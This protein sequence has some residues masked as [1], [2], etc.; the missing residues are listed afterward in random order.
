MACVSHLV[1][2]CDTLWELESSHA[3]KTINN[4]NRYIPN[5][6]FTISL[7]V[8]AHAKFARVPHLVA[9]DFESEFRVCLLVVEGDPTEIH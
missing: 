4:F 8:K 1:L 9:S 5:H 3:F 2:E 6:A 7:T